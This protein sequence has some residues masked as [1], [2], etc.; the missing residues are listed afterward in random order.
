[1]A[2]LAP[3]ETAAHLG[4]SERTLER[5][6]ADG[7]GPPF[8]RLGVRRIAYRVSDIE[9]WAAARTFPHRAAELAQRLAPRAA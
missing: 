8:T 4:L 5:M 1:M 9:E 7:A 2:Y 6:R 3:R